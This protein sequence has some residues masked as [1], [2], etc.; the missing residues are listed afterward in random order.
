MPEKCKTIQVN[1]NNLAF[2]VQQLANWIGDLNVLSTDAKSNLVVA[3]NEIY[4]MVSDSEVFDSRIGDMNNLDTNHKTFLVNA[5]N[6]INAKIGELAELD[7]QD[8]ASVVNAVNSLKN[9]IDQVKITILQ[10]QQDVI[11]NQS[12]TSQNATDILNLTSRVTQSESDIDQNES[13]ISSLNNKL[14]GIISR[15]DGHADDISELQDQVSLNEDKIGNLNN[16]ETSHKEDL[17]GA[18]NE[19]NESGGGVAPQE[20][21]S[22][23]LDDYSTNNVTYVGKA[24]PG[25]LDSESVWQ[26][27]RI[28]ESQGVSVT[29]PNGDDSYSYI[30]GDRVAL[31]DDE[32]SI[33]P[34]FQ[35]V[36]DRA[37][38]EG[39]D[40][41]PEEHL[42]V[43]N[44]QMIR[45]I[46]N[47]VYDS[48]FIILYGH[49]ADQYPDFCRIN[50]KNPSGNLLNYY[51]ALNLMP[52]G[53]QTNAVDS[54]ARY[55]FPKENIPLNAT[56]ITQFHT[57]TIYN[58]ETYY[59]A[60]S[61]ARFGQHARQRMNNN[62]RPYVNSIFGT[63]QSNNQLTGNDIT[64]A[65]RIGDDIHFQHNETYNY[66]VTDVPIELTPVD[67]FDIASNAS[68]GIV[69]VQS[70]IIAN[71]CHAIAAQVTQDLRTYETE[72]NAL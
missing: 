16:L 33:I 21:K 70:V 19:I 36:I 11:S 58:N 37:I 56:L 63:S 42:L 52:T 72:F 29:F 47:G 49:G 22:I 24:E 57:S 60:D 2:R 32:T 31:F 55:D 67:Y 3:I 50:R 18:I 25:S 13:N 10:V 39:F 8:K 62:F 17:V 54:F 69:T 45:D 23:N 15:A 26:I 48:A 68:T 51:N 53:W 6:E 34:E 46:A 7:V 12:S 41:P 44:A 20:P 5:L 61:G 38:A 66:T 65:S 9:E 43:H 71:E 27:Q 40:L 35:A 28:S 64:V 14:D 59:V 30:W 4:S 1:D